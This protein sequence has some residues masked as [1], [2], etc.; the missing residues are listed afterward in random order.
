MRFSHLSNWC[1]LVTAVWCDT[2]DMTLH[3]V[4]SRNNAGPFWGKLKISDMSPS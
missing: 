4:I 3:N 2:S 1:H